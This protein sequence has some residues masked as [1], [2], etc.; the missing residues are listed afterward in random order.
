MIL[1]YDVSKCRATT[2][3][4]VKTGQV[5]KITTFWD[6]TPCAL[7]DRHRCIHGTLSFHFQGDNEYN[8]SLRNVGTYQTTRRHSPNE[9]N[10]YRHRRQNLKSLM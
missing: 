5:V 4:L 3:N 1:W 9:S 2:R 10:P 6:V 8:R 7:V